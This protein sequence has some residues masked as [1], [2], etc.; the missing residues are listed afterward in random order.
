MQCRQRSCR[1]DLENRSP[2]ARAAEPRAA[3]KVAVRSE[4]EPP[5]REIAIVPREIMQRG[6]RAGWRHPK[7]CAGP[8]SASVRG[9]AVQISVPALRQDRR[10]VGLA[11]L[12]P[13]VKIM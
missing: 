2:A 10:I 9:R 12:C 8:G 7:N 6:D 1:S 3:V 13:A 11:P 5:K 4:G